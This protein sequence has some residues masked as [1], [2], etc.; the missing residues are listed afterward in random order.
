[1]ILVSCWTRATR[2]LRRT[3]RENVGLGA[4][5]SS[6]YD[7]CGCGVFLDRSHLVAASHL[8]CTYSI[9]LGCSPRKES[10]DCGVFLDEPHSSDGLEQHPGAALDN[11]AAG[12]RPGAVPDNDAAGVLG[13]SRRSGVIWTICTGNARNDTVPSVVWT[14]EAQN[15]IVLSESSRPGTT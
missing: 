7:S 1:M 3:Q 12:V 5:C 15:D 6:E 4:D 2:Q 10:R 11:G 9:G 13:V 8:E 14:N